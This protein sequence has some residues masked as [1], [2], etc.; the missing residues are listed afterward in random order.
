M[1]G[2]KRRTS[3]LVL[4]WK[5]LLV[6]CATPGLLGPP[7]CSRQGPSPS[8]P[9]PSPAPRSCS[10]PALPT[11]LDAQT[12]ARPVGRLRAFWLPVTATSTRHSSNLRNGQSTAGGSREEAMHGAEG[13]AGRAGKGEGMQA[14]TLLP[15]QRHSSSPSFQPLAHNGCSFWLLAFGRRRRGWDGWWGVAGGGGGRGEP[16]D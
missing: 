12:T 2:V 3:A 1:P 5:G 14:T 9:L 8:P 15:L 10:C 13:R 6:A 7:D 11:F 16:S 4:R